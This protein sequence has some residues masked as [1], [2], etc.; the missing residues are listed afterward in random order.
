MFWKQRNDSG[1]AKI[2]LIVPSKLIKNTLQRVLQKKQNKNSSVLMQTC[3][4]ENIY[5]ISLETF[6]ETVR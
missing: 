1:I 3:A 5:N 2:S 6:T 4:N